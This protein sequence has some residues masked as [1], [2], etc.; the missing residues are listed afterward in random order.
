MPSE[1][2]RGANP[3]SRPTARRRA[4]G[5]SEMLERGSFRKAPGQ[6]AF[7]GPNRYGM[8]PPCM[9][10]AEIWPRFGTSAPPHPRALLF[11]AFR[12]LHQIWKTSETV[13]VSGFRARKM[14]VCEE[15]FRDHSF[16]GCRRF[17]KQVRLLEPST[18][19]CTPAEIGNFCL[20]GT[21]GAADFGE[22]DSGLGLADVGRIWSGAREIKRISD[23]SRTISP[24]LVDLCVAHRSTSVRAESNFAE[25]DPNLADF[26]PSC[27]QLWCPNF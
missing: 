3:W 12:E 24:K 4:R 25:S 20:P 23:V 8:G 26:D 6:R 11:P 17:V 9:D 15:E 19:F 14:A 21:R 7:Q 16:S 18:P 22:V 1:D 2:A 13:S 27:S 10:F 5:R